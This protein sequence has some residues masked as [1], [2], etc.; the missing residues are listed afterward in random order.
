M[1]L[2]VNREDDVGVRKLLRVRPEQP[3]AGLRIRGKVMKQPKSF[4]QEVLLELEA[5]EPDAVAPRGA[6]A[7]QELVHHKG[8]LRIAA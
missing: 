7:L 3:R 2:V 1:K 6:G 5:G 4:V 8:A